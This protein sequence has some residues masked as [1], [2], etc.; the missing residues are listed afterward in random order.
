MGKKNQFKLESQK[1]LKHKNCWLD[2][3]SNYF[4]WSSEV[5]ILLLLCSF[6][7]WLCYLGTLLKNV[8]FLLERIQNYKS[9]CKTEED[10]LQQGRK[11]SI[12]QP[13]GSGSKPLECFR[14][15]GIRYWSNNS[16]RLPDETKIE[17]TQQKSSK[18]KKG[19]LV[20]LKNNC[21]V[22]LQADGCAGIADA[23]AGGGLLLWL[24]VWGKNRFDYKWVCI[25]GLL[26]VDPSDLNR[27]FFSKRQR[28]EALI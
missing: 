19:Q 6:S 14:G 3:E 17:E 13:L 28:L 10:A 22:I 27:E 12:K 26:S 25:T 16:P 18:L 2:P 7:L 9:M 24:D 11:I 15:R 23:L 1:Y 20:E 4:Y 5:R 21:L 8:L